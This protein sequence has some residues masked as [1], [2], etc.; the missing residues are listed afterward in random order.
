ME[1]EKELLLKELLLNT[2]EKVYTDADITVYDILD[3]LKMQLKK[4]MV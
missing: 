2:Y 4:I 1:K 3:Y